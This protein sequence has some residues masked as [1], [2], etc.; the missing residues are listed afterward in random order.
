MSYPQLLEELNACADLTYRDFHKRLLKNGN[1]NVI[2][3]RVPY[4]RSIAKKFKGREGE[5]LTFPDEFYEVTFIKLTACAALPYGEF[6]N[7]VDSC[8]PLINNWASCDS[9]KPKC[10]SGNREAF[11]PYIQ[12]YLNYDGEFYQR[13]A[14]TTLLAFYVEEQY[15]PLITDC[16]AKADTRYYYVRMAAAWLVAEILVKRNERGVEIIKSG[17]LDTNTANK[18]ITKACESFRLSDDRKKYLKS[19][20]R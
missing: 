5:L 19:L 8:V 18:A 2:G 17:I 3:V 10:I 14:L 16:L 12:K 11:I 15:M 1:I 4:L 13:F 9:F 7:I 20:K 6:V